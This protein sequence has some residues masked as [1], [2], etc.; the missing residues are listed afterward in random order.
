MANW[1]NENPGDGDLGQMSTAATDLGDKVTK[2]D[3]VVTSVANSA[4][5]ANETVW[6]GASGVAWRDK[7][8]GRKARV[9][10]FSS[11]FGKVRT[12][13][14][15]YRESVQSIHNSAVVWQDA[16]REATIKMNTPIMMPAGAPSEAV[17]EA[18]KPQRDA[19][20]RL[21]EARTQL[22]QLGESRR[23]ADETLASAIKAALPAGWQET[24]GALVQAGF[25]SMSDLGNASAIE[26]KLLDLAA[27]INDRD[28]DP[29][30]AAGLAAML[31]LY[32]EDEDIMSSF[33]QEL[34]GENTVA[35]VNN[36]G[37][38]GQNDYILAGAAAA[39]GGLTRAGLSVG[40]R[41]WSQYQANEFAGSM[42]ESGWRGGE[43][44]GYLFNGLPQHPLGEN[45]AIAGA[46]EVD[47]WERIGVN[48]WQ[49]SDPPSGGIWLSMQEHGQLGNRVADA[50]GPIFSTLGHYPD[51]AY[52][53]LTDKESGDDR[54]QYWY[55]DRYDNKYW[56]DRTGSTVPGF[57]QQDDFQGVA[58]LWFGSQQVSGGPAHPDALDPVGNRRDAAELAND[59]MTALVN[60]PHFVPENISDAASASL[61]GGFVINIQSFTEYPIGARFPSDHV[62]DVYAFD[63]NGTMLYAPTLS[64]EQLAVFLARA[65]SH[66]S[67][68]EVL[69]YGISSYQETLLNS[70]MQSGNPDDIDKALDRVIEL[71][72]ALDGSTHGQLM[73]AAEATDEGREDLVD[74]IKDVIGAV[75]IPGLRSLGGAVAD[76]VLAWGQGVTI[77]GVETIGADGIKD[78][79]ASQA[80]TV[81]NQLEALENGPM[82]DRM[83][84]TIA[85]SVYEYFTAV[86]AAHASDP[87]YQ[88]IV[89]SIPPPTSST[90]LDTM[91]DWYADHG[92]ALQGKLSEWFQGD[93]PASAFPNDY[94]EDYA[95][96]Y[97]TKLNG[98]EIRVRDFEPP[99]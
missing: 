43:A 78:I 52:Q 95:N 63:F 55:D 45:L 20:E 86:D 19:E 49:S 26:K 56:N 36:I 21:N 51:A 70:A 47:Q 31:K 54:V 7:L 35:L 3:Q 32:G 85:S 12:A 10:E 91:N 83:H 44:I 1:T 82:Q 59:V 33:Y 84:F 93:N 88:P 96:D 46:N 94:F 76:F 38:L 5:A 53:W 41:N 61:A 79:W 11:V 13:I 80:D 98:W 28:I 30:T 27:K 39:L 90:D 99:K 58:D 66:E 68:A 77:G 97:G 89:G 92:P 16:V 18:L 73:D 72:A 15:A 8:N 81:R 60:N 4:T 29:A 71:Q 37:W 57:I 69:T 74:G 2:V 62:A 50:S 65:G 9:G 42:F 6:S 22:A 75:P 64:Q 14:D 34:G 40:S 87:G 17:H 67:G 24:Y 25:T 23:T 48:A